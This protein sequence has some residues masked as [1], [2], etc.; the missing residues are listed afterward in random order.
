MFDVPE[1]IGPNLNICGVP[2]QKRKTNK[3]LKRYPEEVLKL[4]GMV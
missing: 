3:L 1:D 2:A 4:I